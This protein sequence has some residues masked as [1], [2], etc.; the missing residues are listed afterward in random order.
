M[1]NQGAYNIWVY[2]GGFPIGSGWRWISIP[3]AKVDPRDP[4]NDGVNIGR[5]LY[6]HHTNGNHLD[7]IVPVENQGGLRAV[8][9]WL[10][11]SLHFWKRQKQI[12]SSSK[13]LWTGSV[14][15][16]SR[17]KRTDMAW[18]RPAFVADGGTLTLAWSTIARR[19]AFFFQLWEVLHWQVL[20][21]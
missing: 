9:D 21:P 1:Y 12:F 20:F 3:P 10:K 19:W 4:L 11:S 6:L 18:T 16:C 15:L 5:N 8:Q 13:E 7:R 17:P 14:C 2:W